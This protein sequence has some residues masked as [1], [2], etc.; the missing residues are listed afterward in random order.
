MKVNIEQLRQVTL[1]AQDAADAK[2]RQADADAKAATDAKAEKQKEK[3]KRILQ[4]VGDKC[5]K[6]AKDGEYECVV[7]NLKPSHYQLA[8]G[9]GSPITLVEGELLGTAKIV[10]DTLTLANLQPEARS[11]DDGVGIKGGY[12][13][14]VKWNPPNEI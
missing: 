4:Q 11:W 7:M 10:F 9:G 1:E 13:I 6:A 5:M 14:W 8:R 2:Q 12:K 3:A